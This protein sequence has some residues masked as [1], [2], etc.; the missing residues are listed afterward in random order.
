[1]HSWKF[2]DTAS[3]DGA[4]SSMPSIL[5]HSDSVSARL[6]VQMTV[7][8]DNACTFALVSVWFRCALP[9]A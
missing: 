5:P 7:I 9:Q 2:Y 1:M 6:E 8:Y 4:Q 3:Q